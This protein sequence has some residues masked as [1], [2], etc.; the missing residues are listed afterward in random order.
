MAPGYWFKPS[1]SLA[2][3]PR[4]RGQSSEC[5]K[6]LKFWLGIRNAI[7]GATL[8]LHGLHT[9]PS[10]PDET[11]QLAPGERREVRFRAGAS[12]TYYYWATTTTEILPERIGIER[13]GVDSQLNG[14]LIIDPQG[15][16]RDDRV[17]V[18]SWWENPAMRAIGGDPW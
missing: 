6:V 7:P 4:F 2:G 11:V 17:F 13:Y 9:R 14:A 12:G 1:Q 5:P 3:P 15:A 16:R 8:V 10:N 18:I